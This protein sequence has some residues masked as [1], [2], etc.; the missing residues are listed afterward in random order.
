MTLRVR[1]TL[2]YTAVLAA[3]LLVFGAVVYLMLSV[4]LTRQVEETLERTADD[5]LRASQVQ[6]GGI[7]VSAIQLELDLTANVF[8]QVFD[9]Q[10][11][12]VRQTMNYPDLVAPLDPG[13]IG[14]QV[15]T[16]STVQVEETRLRVLTVPVIERGSGQIAGYL[17]LAESLATVD[18]ARR[19]L[20]WVL[21]G[22][23]TFA[24]AL[25]ALVGWVTAGAALRPLDEV[26]DTALS[27]TRA[28]DLSRRIPLLAPPHDE[29]GRLILAFNETLERLENLFQVQ[30]RFLADVSHELRTPLTTIRGNV[31]LIQRMKKADRV[32]LDAIRAEVDRM[33]RLVND[34]L[35]LAKAESGSLPL[36]REEVELDTLML[37]V[38]KQGKV[39]APEGVRLRIAQED[40]ARVLGDRDRLK[41]VML[42][43]V[44]NALDHT[45]PGGTVTMGLACQGELACFTVADTG[46][47][48]PA[49]EI[50]HIFE[51]FYRVDPSRKRKNSGGAGLGLSIA[52]WI[53]RSHGG[54]IEV[55]SEV[56]K[57]TTFR[58]YLPLMDGCCGPAQRE[59]GR[60]AQ[61]REDPAPL[62]PQKP[63]ER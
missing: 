21:V 30:R 8:V 40:Q 47:G 36:A 10:G 38:F 59:A 33:T 49:D 48:I 42:N 20:L 9:P 2:W 27:I 37:D 58:V 14:V 62:S 13:H 56:G 12:L 52:Y 4:S 45:P 31:D 5:L 61:V 50:P 25:A 53:T 39:L 51:R 16:F 60:D 57:G 44:A 22:G 11:N 29:V 26:T 32:S 55:Q 46:R 63:A 23:G 7:P 3:L 43:L 54:R 24:V 41:Q 15:P 19:V 34:L 35:L 6:I 1:L 18:S 17:Q 28:D